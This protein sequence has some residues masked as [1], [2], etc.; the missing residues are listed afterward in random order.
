[1][2]TNPWQSESGQGGNSYTSHNSSSQQ[3]HPRPD[4]SSHEE[5]RPIYQPPQ[6]DYRQSQWQEPSQEWTNQDPT[7][8]PWGGHASQTQSYQPPPQPYQPQSNNR[9]QQPT[10][11]IRRSDTDDLLEAEPDRAEQVEHM[12]QYEA[13]KPLSDDDRNQEELQR[14]FPGIDSSLIAAIYN[15]HKQGTGRVDM[16]Q[17][18]EMLQELQS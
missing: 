13:S 3:S 4:Q 6:Q 9:S 18:R 2:D 5:S 12:Q 1:M 10:P 8:N 14:Q 16:P 15:D 7:D 11:G 17:I